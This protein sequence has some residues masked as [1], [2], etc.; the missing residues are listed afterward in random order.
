MTYKETG[1][2]VNSLYEINKELFNKYI[3]KCK[4]KI[5]KLNFNNKELQEG[6][7]IYQDLLNKGLI[8]GDIKVGDVIKDHRLNMAKVK[9]NHTYRVVNDTETICNKIEV[10][11]DFTEVAKLASLFHDI[12]RFP[13]AITS[14]TFHDKECKLFNGLSHAEYGYKMLYIDKM[15]ND[16]QVPKEYHY[17]LALAVLNHQKNNSSDIHFNNVK[18]LDVNSLKGQEQLSKQEFII[19]STLTQLVRDVDK[20]DILYQHITGEFP[21]VRPFIKYEINGKTLDEICSKYNIDKEILKNYNNLENDNLENRKYINIPSDYV[22]LNKLVVPN[23]IKDSFFQNKDLD[24]KKLQNREDYSFIVGMW[25]RLNHFLNDINFVAN[26]EILKENNTLEKIYNEFPLRYKF[27][28]TEAFDFA[29]EEILDK[30]LEENKGK[31]F[32]KK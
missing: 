22:D 14:N 5:E 28:V 16:Y 29:K 26:L 23:D 3:L 2:N 27:L 18:E 20:I 19:I 31:V 15:L 24:L 12:A 4:D 11:N 10:N 25:W 8:T 1:D 32:V 21:V 9:E 6:F 30:K 17:A 13:Q 7:A